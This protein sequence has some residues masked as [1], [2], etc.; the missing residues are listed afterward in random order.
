MSRIVLRSQFSLPVLVSNALGLQAT[1]HLAQSEPITADPIE[2]LTNDAGLLKYDI[3][4]SDTTTV[5]FAD[6]SIPIRCRCE[7]TDATL[8][9]RVKLATATALQEF[10]TLVLGDH[11]LHLEQQLIFGTAIQRSVEENHLNATALELVDQQDLVDIRS[12]QAVRRLDVEPVEGTGR[13]RVAQPGQ[14]RSNQRGTTI[15]AIDE[16]E[17]CHQG[18]GVLARPRTQG[19]HLTSDYVC[20]GFSFRSD[21]DIDRGPNRLM[22]GHAVRPPLTVG[23]IP[24]ESGSSSHRCE[25]NVLVG[26]T[27]A[28]FGTSKA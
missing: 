15:T 19:A 6:V 12:R 3:E 2:N 28:L 21:A 23:P 25:S 17:V 24:A 5:S 26:L 9:R 16:A 27:E 22:M 4:A 14:G 10:R 20:I 8:L 7:S 18:N 13:G 11:A 1:T